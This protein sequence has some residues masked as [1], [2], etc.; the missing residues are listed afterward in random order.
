[1]ATV[2]KQGRPPGDHDQRRQEVA[3]AVWAVL[4]DKGLEGITLRA[5][6]REGGFT[7][8]VL[9]H[10]FRDK[11]ELLHF[12]IT[13]VFDQMD[14]RWSA[15]IAANPPLE[16]IRQIAAGILPTTQ[17]SRLEWAA[18][19][20]FIAR[21]P[22]SPGFAELRERRTTRIRAVIRQLIARAIESGE[23]DPA[24]DPRDRADALVGFVEGMCIVNTS[25]DGQIDEGRRSQ[26]VF[27][28]LPLFLPPPQTPGRVPPA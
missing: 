16:A 24:V 7:T 8:G 14:A 20:G 27:D 11:D 21:G 28:H 12:S 1:M 26:L 22:W 15:I 18:W 19:L 13:H 3:E 5:V 10:Y 6:A 4:R 2:Q 17:Q 9:S 23:V 25:I